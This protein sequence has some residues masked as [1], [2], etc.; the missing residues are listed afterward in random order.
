VIAAITA[1][2][3]KATARR[4]RLASSRRVG[5][6]ECHQARRQPRAGGQR[7][8]RPDAGQAKGRRDRR[9]H[10]GQ[11]APLFGVP[12]LVDDAADAEADRQGSTQEQQVGLGDVAE[13]R[14]RPQQQGGQPGRCEVERDDGQQQQRQRDQAPR[15]QHR[16][17]RFRPG[18]RF[19]DMVLQADA[20]A[21]VGEQKPALQAGQQREDRV[22][23]EPE[24]LQQEPHRDQL[25][26]G[27]D[28]TGGPTAAGDQHMARN[29]KAPAGR[30]GRLV[31]GGQ[32]HRRGPGGGRLRQRR[33][34]SRASARHPRQR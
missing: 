32:H 14:E 11:V 4:P 3:Q 34:P 25:H 15:Q 27:C 23:V 22:A 28:Q 18:A 16:C 9:Q 33:R 26:D 2:A 12:D 1:K 8:D 19:G 24:V 5:H 21:Q 17:G 6:D 13:K 31:G 7:A 20:E 10:V 30:G 29:A